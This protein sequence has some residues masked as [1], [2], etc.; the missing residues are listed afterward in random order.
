MLANR[1]ALLK[2]EEEKAWRRIEDT[3]KKATDVRIL[4]EATIQ[5]AII[6]EQTF[7]TR[8]DEVVQQREK[9]IEVREAAKHHRND[10]F[11]ELHQ[12]RRTQAQLTKI[13]SETIEQEKKERE[14]QHREANCVRYAASRQVKDAVVQR[15]TQTR[16]A[17]L[18]NNRAV[19]DARLAAEEEV[20]T[21]TE[22]LV[23]QM[24][25]EE[26]DLIQRLANT[27]TVQDTASEELMTA[28][29]TSATPAAP[30]GC[31][32]TPTL[33]RALAQPPRK[34]WARRPGTA[35]NAQ[36]MADSPGKRSLTKT[37][38]E[39]RLSPPDRSFT[40][41][42]QSANIIGEDDEAT[43]AYNG[44]TPEPAPAS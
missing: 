9:N 12:S 4:R 32:R 19:Y 26:M 37:R 15:Q 13:N 3:R 29:T 1:I 35:G 44:A 41:G 42:S 7:H 8:L 34:G 40:D 5:K 24:E 28:L 17:K 14:L 20:K 36:P 31:E 25:K 18:E 21:Q 39:T 27:R 33:G 30:P 23:R 38:S 10:V 2:Q 11:T 16:T 22:T 43:M 6:K